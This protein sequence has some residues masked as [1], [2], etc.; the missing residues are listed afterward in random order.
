[1]LRHPSRSRRRQAPGR[2]V[3]RPTWATNFLHG[4]RLGQA[5]CRVEERT[6]LTADVVASV[7]IYKVGRVRW[8]RDSEQ[9]SCS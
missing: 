9:R 1:M 4:N 3:Q 7:S 8:D 6:M 5:D 2:S